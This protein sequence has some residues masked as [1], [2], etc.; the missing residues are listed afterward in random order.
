MSLIRCGCKRVSSHERSVCWDNKLQRNI[1]M[2][3]I[4]QLRGYVRSLEEEELGQHL[5]R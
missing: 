3:V 5:P 2:L 1:R 4:L